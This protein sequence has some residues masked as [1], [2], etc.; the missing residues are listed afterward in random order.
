[1]SASLPAA[2]PMS[3]RRCRRQKEPSLVIAVFHPLVLEAARRLGRSV[4]WLGD[5]SEHFVGDAQ[6]RADDGRHSLR[7]DPEMAGADHKF[8]RR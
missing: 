1:M 2:L 6:G 5:R 4:S 3:P 8:H 7:R